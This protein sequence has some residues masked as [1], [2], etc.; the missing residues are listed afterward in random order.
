MEN[1][2]KGSLKGEGYPRDSGRGRVGGGGIGLE[3]RGLVE[4]RARPIGFLYLE[5]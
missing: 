5:M 2:S 4:I 1:V 3:E